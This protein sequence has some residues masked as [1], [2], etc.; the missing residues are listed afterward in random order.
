MNEAAW[1]VTT[2]V[3]SFT[4]AS[5]A[6][7]L[8]LAEE[9]PK[10]TRALVSD[11]AAE[12]SSTHAHRA[13]H[14]GRLCLLLLSAAS[15]A[16]ALHWWDRPALDAA[17]V[18]VIALGFLYMVADALPRA[19]SA[20]APDLAAAAVPLAA[21]TA[22]AFRPL[23]A[24]VSRV[25]RIV[26]AALP[27]RRVTSKQT[28]ESGQRDL[29]MGVFSLGDST[30]ADIMTPRLDVVALDHKA[31]WAEVVE[32]VRR[33]EHARTPVYI[34]NLDNIAGVLYAKDLV[35]AVG[36]AEPQPERWQDLIRPPQFVPESKTLEF[37]PL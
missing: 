3:A 28:G 32:T 8:A 1:T 19:V 31:E 5:W 33:G 10:V 9:S 26:H 25:E 21:R 17:G 4:M 12:S 7:I 20:L 37:T 18:S 23:L 24:L 13:I 2:I 27:K 6:A 30:V 14:V 15:A 34:D 35:P 22:S 29:L 16:Q 11:I 36:G